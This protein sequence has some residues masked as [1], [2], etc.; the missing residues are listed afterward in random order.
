MVDD[1][2][3]RHGDAGA[4]GQAAAWSTTAYTGRDLDHFERLS[5]FSSQRGAAE[6][7]AGGAGP[8]PAGAAAFA[9]SNGDMQAFSRLMGDLGQVRSVAT[10]SRGTGAW[11]DYSAGDA[12]QFSALMAPER[13]A[14]G[15]SVAP[16]GAGP[17]SDSADAV[18][19]SASDR[20]AFARIMP[21]ATATE[22]SGGA[23][24]SWL[25]SDKDRDVGPIRV[26]EFGNDQA[27]SSRRNRL[28][29]VKIK[30]R[31]FD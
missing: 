30:V 24:E 9:Y 26:V 10:R 13:F 17:S 7:S 2:K 23:T 1:R 28:S 27:R 12:A 29:D 11:G 18:A 15:G 3:D 31:Y 5:D 6:S 8:G 14:A 25:P 21:D 4:D 20:A 19:Y 22:E 16:R